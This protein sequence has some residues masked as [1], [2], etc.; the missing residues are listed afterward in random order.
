MDGWSFYETDPAAKGYMTSADESIHTRLLFMPNTT[1]DGTKTSTTIKSPEHSIALAITQLQKVAMTT[2]SS[3]EEV[4]I[5]LKKMPKGKT[6]G[7]DAIPIESHQALW[8][9]F[10]RDVL[11]FIEEVLDEGQLLP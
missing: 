8:D 6:P 10:S 3:A 9:D 2:L 4:D 11:L 1:G 7:I 5:T